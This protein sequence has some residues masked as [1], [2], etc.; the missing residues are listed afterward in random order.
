VHRLDRINAKKP[1]KLLGSK[2]LTL[3]FRVKRIWSVFLCLYGQSCC[4]CHVTPFGGRNVD[5]IGYERCTCT[6]R[7]SIMALGA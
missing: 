7:R 3:G 1:A 5:G 6:A 4:P 2:S